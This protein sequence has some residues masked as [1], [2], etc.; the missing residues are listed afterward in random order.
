MLR[1]W[2]FSTVRLSSNLIS[3]F[4]DIIVIL[5]NPRTKGIKNFVSVANWNIL[6]NKFYD[7]YNIDNN[8]RLT[9]LKSFHSTVITGPGW[10]NYQFYDYCSTLLSSRDGVGL[11]INTQ[12]TTVINLCL[13]NTILRLTLMLC[14]QGSDENQLY[15][16]WTPCLNITITISRMLQIQ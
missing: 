12:Y 1:Y 14:T 13:C 3:R 2:N 7:N 6:H 11:L 8:I 15:T 4:H 10:Y 5:P 16:E 9:V